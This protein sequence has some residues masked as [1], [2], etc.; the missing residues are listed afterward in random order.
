MNHWCV[1]YCQKDT[2]CTQE[3]VGMLK[4]VAKVIGMNIREPQM[5]CLRDDRIETY[6]QALKKNIDQTVNLM[7]IVFPT[8]RTDRYSAVKR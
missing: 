4:N 6:V 3:F 1:L 5:I 2:R 7:V 8:N